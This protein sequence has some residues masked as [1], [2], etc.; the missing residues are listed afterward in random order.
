MKKRSVGAI[1]VGTSVLFCCPERPKVHARPAA[2]MAGNTWHLYQQALCSL[3]VSLVE[4]W[5]LEF[6]LFSPHSLF[7]SPP[8]YPPTS[9]LHQH[10]APN[11]VDDP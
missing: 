2:G 9:P 11:A 6:L 5:C 10:S 8:S 7:S 4:V 3:F 1:S